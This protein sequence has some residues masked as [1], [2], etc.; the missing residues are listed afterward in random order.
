LAGT[1][2]KID[3]QARSS[4]WED[5]QL[6]RTTEVNELNGA[7]V[8]LANSC[9]AQAPLNARMVVLIQEAEQGQRSGMT[10]EDLL[11]ALR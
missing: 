4:M 8:K 10:G 1:M 6:G 3:E 7:V 5:L 9:G 11:Q 2:L